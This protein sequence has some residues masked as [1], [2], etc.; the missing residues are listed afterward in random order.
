[1]AKYKLEYELKGKTVKIQIEEDLQKLLAHGHFCPYCKES[2]LTVKNSKIV[3][4]I[5]NTID[6]NRL[7][8]Y[9]FLFS[10]ANRK[11]CCE[12]CVP[13]LT[14]KAMD[15]HFRN[16]HIAVVRNWL[17]KN[18][19]GRIKRL[20]EKKGDTYRDIIMKRNGLDPKSMIDYVV[21][22][23][24]DPVGEAIGTDFGMFLK[25]FGEENITNMKKELV[26]HD[27]IY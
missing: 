10:K 17:S 8:G 16:S 9:K 11:V 15:Y 1:M 2:L 12:D 20:P 18:P 25:V 6:N 26:I 27:T 21:Y 3:Y 24:D 22:K 14:S 4:L 13:V 7:Y 19:S 5:P 23:S